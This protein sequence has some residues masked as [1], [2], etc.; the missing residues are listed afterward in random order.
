MNEFGYDFKV[1][2]PRLLTDAMEII[3]ESFTYRELGIF[4]QFRLIYSK[5]QQ[6]KK[7]NDY[8]LINITSQAHNEIIQLIL[9]LND[10]HSMVNM[11]IIEK[12]FY[13]LGINV[14][15]LI[16]RKLFEEH[17]NNNHSINIGWLET[18]LNLSLIHI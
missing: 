15:T 9:W 12:Y 6:W 13:Y 7:E 11:S 4:N 17:R 8:R 18:L 1:I 16:I 5:I 14:R 2:E 10:L 3:G